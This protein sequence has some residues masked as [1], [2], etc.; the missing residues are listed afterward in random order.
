MNDDVSSK[1]QEAK[2][3]DRIP[4]MAAVDRL[5]EGAVVLFRH[6]RYAQPRPAVRVEIADGTLHWEVAGRDGL[7]GT[8]ELFGSF[9]WSPVT[10]LH[11]EAQQ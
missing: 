4:H 2:V 11:M 3:G 1:G 6:P 9:G 10:V 8:R 5:P 7:V